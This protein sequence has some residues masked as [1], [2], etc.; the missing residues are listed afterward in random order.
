MPKANIHRRDSIEQVYPPEAFASDAAKNGRVTNEVV[1]GVRILSAPDAGG[2][3]EFERA[4]R[5]IG[6]AASPAFLAPFRREDDGSADAS[7]KAAYQEFLD[8]LANAAH[9]FGF[10]AEETPG[11]DDPRIK[12]LR[13]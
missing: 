9:R 8:Q 4:A 1:A 3:F 7:L 12:G 2:D 5:Q 6:E 11:G 10:Q 13:Q